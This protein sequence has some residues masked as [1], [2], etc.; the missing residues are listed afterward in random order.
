MKPDVSGLAAGGDAPQRD[1][2]R[3]GLEQWLDARPADVGI[4]RER[5]RGRR[6]HSPATNAISA[7]SPA[8]TA[9]VI[10]TLV[11]PRCTSAT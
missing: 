1:A 9:P 7:P 11:G 8:N 6:S 5:R 4:Y 10:L 2:G 3:T